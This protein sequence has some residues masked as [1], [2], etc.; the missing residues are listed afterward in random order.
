LRGVRVLVLEQ[1]AVARQVVDQYLL[2]WGAFASSTGNAAHAIELAKAS[3]ARRGAF[4][5]IIVDRRA[6]GDAFSFAAR[7][8]SVPGFE[9]VPMV[10]VTGADE[11]VQ[12]ADAR[13]AG[14][15]AILRKPIRQTALHE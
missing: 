9:T 14:F 8:R 3:V 12:P 2:A 10:L 5:V 11:T 7:L 6:G 15:A 1:E 4:D 13:A